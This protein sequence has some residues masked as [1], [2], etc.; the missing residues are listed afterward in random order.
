MQKLVNKTT[1]LVKTTL[2]VGTLATAVMLG[3]GVSSTAFAHEEAINTGWCSGGQITILGQFKLNQALLQ[4]F[5]KESSGVCSQL[6]SCG[7]FDDEY[8]VA[9]KTAGALCH[10][11]SEAELTYKNIGD[12]L[13]VRA[14]FHSPATMKNSEANHHTLYSFEQGL[15]F[16]CGLCELGDSAVKDDGQHAKSR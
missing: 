4:Q 1:N 10:S 6:K 5:A 13:S 2:K 16:S 9:Y 3:A 8:G 12:H 14:I 7:Q 15:E 11:F